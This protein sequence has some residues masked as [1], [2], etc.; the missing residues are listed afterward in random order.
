MVRPRPH[1]YDDGREAVRKLGA[2]GV[3]RCVAEAELVG[4]HNT[5]HQLLVAALL[6]CVA[7]CCV[8]RVRLIS[9]DRACVV[10][11]STAQ[12]ARGRDRGENSALSRAAAKG[13]RE[14]R[15]VSVGVSWVSVCVS[16]CV[17]T[18]DSMYLKR[19]R[20]SSSTGGASCAEG[21]AGEGEKENK[22]R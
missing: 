3:V 18:T 19:F 12:N 5:V 20:W 10:S 1:V 16:V 13:I 2:G 21:H 14:A 4:E 6:L 8:A 22:R 15:V 11:R 17:R 9:M 7:L